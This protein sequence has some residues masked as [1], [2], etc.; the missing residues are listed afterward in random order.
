M[1]H[2]LTAV[3]VIA[4]P[5]LS[6][7][8][9]LRRADNFAEIDAIRGDGGGL[10]LRF[11]DAVSGKPIADGRVRLGGQSARTG[12]DGR[13]LLPWPKGLAA[14]DDERML[15]FAAPG[16]ITT[17][18]KVRFQARTIFNNRFSISPQ[19]PTPK[20][21]RVVL[22]WGLKPAD[23]DAHL[24]KSGSYHISYR[25][26][27]SYQDLVNLDRDDV[28]GEGPETI[29]I[30]RVDPRGSYR[31]FVHDYSNRGRSNSTALSKSQGRV[32]VFGNGRLLHVFRVPSQGPGHTW[33]VFSIEAGV[34]RAQGRLR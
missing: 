30:R 16:Y 27:K 13:A 28:N 33:E 19:L 32:M 22:D 5:V 25:H 15:K 7:D 14:G 3:A 18:L 31:F 1:L 23:L 10:A 2:L 29:T 26:K 21:L 11:Y 8:G 6:K 9:A 12:R 17:E 34:V 4:S 24:S 20:H